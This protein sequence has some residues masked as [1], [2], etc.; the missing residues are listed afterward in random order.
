[1]SPS[2]EWYD[3][4]MELSK[5]APAWR[6]SLVVESLDTHI[7]Y[8]PVTNIGRISPTPLLM[9]LA[10]DDVITPTAD[11]RAAFDRAGQPKKLVIVPGR[12]FDAYNGP[13]HAQFVGPAVAGNRSNLLPAAHSCAASGSR[14]PRLAQLDIR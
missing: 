2:T 6:N 14:P 10:S 11:A 9:I 7:L 4:F 3:A 12:H 13:K 8:E 1:M 5:P